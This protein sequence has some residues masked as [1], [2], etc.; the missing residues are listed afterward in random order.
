MQSNN[1]ED[2]QIKYLQGYIYI[3]AWMIPFPMALAM[4]PAPMNPICLELMSEKKQ[5]AGEKSR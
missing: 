4:L 5:D 1:R 3:P 2:S